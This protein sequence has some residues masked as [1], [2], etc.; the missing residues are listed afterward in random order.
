MAE[1][2]TCGHGLAE[3]GVLPATVGRLIASLAEVL[4]AH[5]PS[6]DRS[7]EDARTEHE[8]YTRLVAQH[9]QIAAQLESAAQEMIGYRDLPMGRHDPALLASPRM[10]TAFR[11][12]VETE[13]E[14]LA[15][16]EERVG[17]DDAMLGQMQEA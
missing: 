3:N 5:I 10:V 9:R 15:L 1:Q 7:D 11:Q 4:D 17:Q 6:L 13:K 2:H 12:F 16:L 14:L 8:A